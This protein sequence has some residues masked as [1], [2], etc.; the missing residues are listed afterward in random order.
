MF[1]YVRAFKKFMPRKLKQAYKNYYCGTCFALQKNYGQMFRFLLSY[2]MVLIGILTKSHED[3]LCER[4]PCFGQRNQKEQFASAKWERVAALSLLLTAEKLRDDIEDENSLK[5][6]IAAHTL[7]NGI[8]KAKQEH[9]DMA[10]AIAAGYQEVLA[11][12]KAK[13]STIEIAECFSEMMGNAY[14]LVVA[15]D[16]ACTE[17]MAYV[18]AVSEW[19]YFIDALDDYEKDA[20]KGC[21]NPLA[22]SSATQF[23]YVNKNILEVLGLIRHFYESLNRASGAINP[24]CVEDELLINIAINSI[25]SMTA[26]ILNGNKLPKMKH[27]HA[28]SEWGILCANR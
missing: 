6:K 8:K 1:G 4:I 12:E 20:Q 3:P 2:D 28:K 25:P 10:S 9:P 7:S 11:A 5:A 24:A 18:K 27:F 26:T 22:K 21:F 23:D 15:D 17:K 14:R 16:N 13:K 19:V